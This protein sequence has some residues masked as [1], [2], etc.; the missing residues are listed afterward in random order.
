MK[1]DFIDDEL[2]SSISFSI[3]LFSINSEQMKKMKPFLSHFLNL[4][5]VKRSRL[6]N[7]N[8]TKR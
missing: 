3:S 7:H 5:F 2:M 6:R 4:K 1:F 8:E